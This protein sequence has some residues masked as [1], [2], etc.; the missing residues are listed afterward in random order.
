MAVDQTIE[1][2]Y[3]VL[4]PVLDV[5]AKS[6]SLCL[7]PQRL[8]PSAAIQSRARGMHGKAAPDSLCTAKSSLRKLHAMQAR[9]AE[10]SASAPWMDESIGKISC[11][12]TEMLTVRRKHE[13]MLNKVCTQRANTHRLE[14]SA[15]P[16]TLQIKYNYRRY[17][18]CQGQ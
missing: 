3:K 14:C 2:M 13:E 15:T 8:D 16:P 10:R 7:P 4:P 6:E 9:L 5:R 18:G 12:L 11:I 1:D 17:P